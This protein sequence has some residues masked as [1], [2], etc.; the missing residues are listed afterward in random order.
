MAL[1]AT[2]SQSSFK[3]VPA[4]LFMAICYRVIDLG[5]QKT[6]W[7][8]KEKW[9]RKVLIQWELH[10]EDDAGEPLTTD[11]GAPLSVSKRYTLSLGENA[12]LR[13][14]LKSWRGRDF[15]PDE[16][17]GFDIGKLIGAPCMVNVAHDQKDGNT[18]TNVASVTPVPRALKDTVPAPVN[19]PLMFDVSEPNMETFNLLSD[20]LQETIRA[21]K[22]WQKVPVNEAASASASPGGGSIADMDDDISF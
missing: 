10:G 8:G 7:Q 13:A 18:Y 20:K 19:M 16:L 2:A 22:E 17:A 6:Q 11:E 15:T 21:C 5:T 4:G 12:Q 1:I 3:Q 9:S 14:D